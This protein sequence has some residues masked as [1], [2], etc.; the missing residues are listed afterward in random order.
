MWTN[1]W[2]QTGQA[3]GK[4]LL[5]VI[6]RDV[7]DWRPGDFQQINPAE[8]PPNT[9]CDSR[10]F[11]PMKNGKPALVSITSGSPAAV[12]VHTPDVCF[13]G[14]GWKLRGPV[15]RQTISLQG[16][17][18]GSFWVGDFTKT[19]ATSTE[20]IR[21][22]W[23]WSADGNWVAPDYPRWALARAPILYKLYLVHPL[24]EEEDLTHD[25]PYRRFAADLL[26]VLSQ[27]LR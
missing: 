5:A 10:Y 7:G 23:S 3:D 15:A 13:L 27:Q 24:A 25:D 6:A 11:V 2:S 17:A 14:A 22:R 4:N 19:T 18:T 16:G 8:V 21:V 26:P 9:H 1:R 12:A 20:S